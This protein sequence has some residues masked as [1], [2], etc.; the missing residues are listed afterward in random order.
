MT[1]KNDQ[2]SGGQ[3]ERVSFY[4][5]A[6]ADDWQLFMHPDVL[7]DLQSSAIKVIFIVS[8]AGDAG[9]KDGYWQAREDG[10]KS[11]IRFCLAPFTTCT[12]SGGLR[13]FGIH[14]VQ[15]WSINHTISY[16]LRLPD[17]NLDGL[18]FAATRFQSLAKLGSGDIQFINAIDGS[19]GYDRGQLINT[20][21]S[22]ITLESGPCSNVHI[23]YINPEQDVNPNDHPDHAAT[24]KAIEDLNLIN[25]TTQYL[26]TG[27]SLASSQLHLT[28]AELFWKAGMLAVY[29]KAVYDGCGYSTL[30]ENPDLYIRWT[31]NRQQVTRILAD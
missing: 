30:R 17:G 22:I 18:G 2:N 12:E 20:I 28:V 9:M 5:V 26:Y 10:M 25:K 27:Y 23:H 19:T 6:H 31:S 14:P 3:F 4:V 21:E 15:Y 7:M 24:G 1:D 11:S 29:E 16:F 13:N 8:T